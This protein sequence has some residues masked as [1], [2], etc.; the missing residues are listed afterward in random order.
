M[1]FFMCVSIPFGE[2]LL[3]LP[4]SASKLHNRPSTFPGAGKTIFVVNNSVG[5]RRTSFR[6]VT[7]NGCGYFSR[8]IRYLMS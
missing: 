7:L 3:K 2:S 8:P 1:M 6:P 4:T 5:H